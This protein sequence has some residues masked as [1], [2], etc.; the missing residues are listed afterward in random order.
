MSSG[1]IGGIGVF[2][3]IMVIW[4]ISFGLS[5]FIKVPP[6]IIALMI[7]GIVILG[8]LLLVASYA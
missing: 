8:A 5:K 4:L 1:I 6:R 2:F 3:V 7:L